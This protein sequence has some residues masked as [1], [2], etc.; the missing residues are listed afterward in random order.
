MVLGDGAF[1]SLNE[2]VRI[3]LSWWDECTYKKAL[4]SLF[5]LSPQSQEE[6]SLETSYAATL[7]LDSWPPKL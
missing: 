3:G 2:V 1:G 6:L 5:F 7:I 4:E